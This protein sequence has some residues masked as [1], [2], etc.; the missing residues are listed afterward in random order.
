MYRFIFWQNCMSPHQLPYIVHLLEDTRVDEVVIVTDEVVSQE[1]KKMGWDVTTFPGLELCDV[2]LS[3]S[4]NEIHELLAKRQEDSIHLFSGIHGYPFVTKVL[5]MSLKY[6]IKRG[7]ITER[8]N[9]FKFGLANGKPLWLH[10]IRFLI[11]DRKYAKHIQYV[12]AMG[13]EAVQYFRSIWKDWQVF[14]F[15]YCTNS[16]NKNIT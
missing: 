15:I 1:R 13:E 4:D 16:K 12:F 7:I 10:R 9:T 6:N 2:R 3:P 11:Q 8:P 14:P 5:D